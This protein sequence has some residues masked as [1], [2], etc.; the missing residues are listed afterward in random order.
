MNGITFG[1]YHS[2]DDLKL[3]LS[4][5]E[6]DP[7]ALQENYLE[8]PYRNSLLDMSEAFGKLAYKKRTPK[9]TFRLL[10]GTASWDSAVRTVSNAIHGKLIKIVYDRDPS[11]YLLGR[12]SIDSFKSD[13]RV[14]TLVISAVC[15]PFKYKLQRTSQTF[16]VSETLDVTLTNDRMT[17]Y[18]QVTTTANMQVV[19]EDNSF[20]FGTVSGYQSK[21]KLEKGQNSLTVNGTGSITFNWQEGAL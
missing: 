2:Y 7:P 18:P 1:E 9:Y 11:Y 10:K 4:S 20:S 21:I 13:K 19:Q 17:A 6:D 12:A 8:V 16:T 3:L 14:G 15:D 5:I